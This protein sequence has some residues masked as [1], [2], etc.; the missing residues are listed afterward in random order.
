MNPLPQSTLG[1]LSQ[2]KTESLYLCF[3]WGMTEI[4]STGT[5]SPLSLIL[6]PPPSGKDQGQWNWDW[7]FPLLT[8]R[9]KAYVMESKNGIFL[10]LMIKSVFR[11]SRATLH[12]FSWASQPTY[13]LHS[14]TVVPWLWP[15]GF[16]FSPKDRATKEIS[17]WGRHNCMNGWNMEGFMIIALQCSIPCQL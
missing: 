5:I 13:L 15:S 2:S 12:H 17:I 3:I 8:S 1:S 6:I 4:E 10:N 11:S 16:A 9:L 7:S 14:L